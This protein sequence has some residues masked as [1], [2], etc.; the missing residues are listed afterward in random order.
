M[1]R[2]TRIMTEYGNEFE[3]PQDAKKY[4]EKEYSDKLLK[5]SARAVALEKA[6]KYVRIYR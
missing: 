2:V 4:L 1:Y 3:S 6:Y 5:L